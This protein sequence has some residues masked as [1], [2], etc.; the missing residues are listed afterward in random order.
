MAHEAGTSQ[1]G[2]NAAGEAVCTH[3]DTGARCDWPHKD[4]FGACIVC[5]CGW[6]VRPQSW[7]QHSAPPLPPPDIGADVPGGG[8][9]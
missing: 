6:P 8:A 9:V 3:V 4:G 7:Q 2:V 5:S 1:R